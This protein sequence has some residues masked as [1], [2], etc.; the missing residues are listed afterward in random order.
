MIIN[1]LHTYK[2]KNIF[3]K[4]HYKK[5]DQHYHYYFHTSSANY[6]H[7]KILFFPITQNL[8]NF[9]SHFIWQY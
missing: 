3:I 9:A 7:E 5:H 6:S 2:V 8:V 4:S 1:I